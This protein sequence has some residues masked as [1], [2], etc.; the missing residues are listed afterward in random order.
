MLDWTLKEVEKAG[1]TEHLPEYLEAVAQLLPT[2][3]LQDWPLRF[4]PW[5]WPQLRGLLA[6][7]KAFSNGEKAEAAFPAHDEPDSGKAPATESAPPGRPY[8]AAPGKSI[9]VPR[10]APGPAPVSDDAKWFMKLVVPIPHKG[11]PRDEY[12]KHPDTI[13]SLFELRHGNDDESQAARQRLWGFVE[14]YEPKGWTKRDGTEMPPSAS[15]LKFR[16]A[17]DAFA[18]W[19][20]REHPD[21]KL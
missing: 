12:L 4:V 5:S 16:E 10:D 3:N 18:E 9:E 1:F 19:F 13:G 8:M 21:E 2:E 11:E 7:L 17:L 6:K 15:D 20:K 14:H